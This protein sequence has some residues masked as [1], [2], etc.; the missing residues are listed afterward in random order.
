KDARP[1]QPAG[2]PVVRFEGVAG[3]FAQHD[4]GTLPLCYLDGGTEELT[5]YARRLKWSRGLH[6]FLVPDET[7]ESLIRGMEAFA[8]AVGGL[9]QRNVVDNTKAAVIT[10]KKERA[11]GEERI[12]YNAHFL[13]FL[14][15]VDV[16][17]EPTAPYSGNQKG[18]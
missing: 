3:G 2:P 10:R 18:S 15:A 4:F 13:S 5:F 12:E 17:P 9:P 16:W 14:R 8:Q 11:T 1:P 6:V 7:A